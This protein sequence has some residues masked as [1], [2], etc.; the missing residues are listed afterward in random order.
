M[1]VSPLRIMW[2]SGSGCKWHGLSRLWIRSWNCLSLS[3]AVSCNASIEETRLCSSN[4][5]GAW[6][7]ISLVRRRG[8]M[9]GSRLPSPEEFGC[10][11][12]RCNGDE[13]SQQWRL[14]DGPGDFGVRSRRERADQQ[15]VAKYQWAMLLSSGSDRPIGFGCKSKRALPRWRDANR[16]KTGGT[17]SGETGKETGACAGAAAYR[18]TARTTATIHFMQRH[19]RHQQYGPCS[20]ELQRRN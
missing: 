9:P 14:W 8:A 20:D 19:H 6:W 18:S 17:S 7:S 15:G 4:D 2:S 3:S 16:C 12:A 1:T 10:R 5:G 11:T 13:A